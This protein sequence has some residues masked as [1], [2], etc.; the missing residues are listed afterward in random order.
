MFSILFLCFRFLIYF[1]KNS[2]S[3]LIYFYVLLKM[4][5]PTFDG[6]ICESATVFSS[7]LNCTDVIPLIRPKFHFRLPTGLRA[8]MEVKARPSISGLQRPNI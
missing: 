4:F 7:E 2:V 3:V 5:L 6:D 1:I 8:H